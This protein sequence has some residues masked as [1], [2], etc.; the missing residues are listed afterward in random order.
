MAVVVDATGTADSTATNGTSFNYTGITVG[1]GSNRA[2]IF[3]LVTSNA[4]GNFATGATATWDSGGTNQAMTV[5]KSQQAT[6]DNNLG[7]VWIFGLRNPVAGNKTLAVAWTNA[8][9][10][11]ACAI[12]FT[13]VDQTSDAIAFP[14]SNSATATS[15]GLSLAITSAA[16]NI[17]ITG[18]TAGTIS[19]PNQT[20]I[21]LD[22]VA[23][24]DGGGQ[25]AAGAASVT[26]TWTNGATQWAMA[27]CDV[28][29]SG[30]ADVLM[31]QIWL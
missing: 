30:S 9:G 15:G 22:T 13:G 16:G 31:A 19:A 7:V 17:P 6:G 21:F 20:Q 12:S 1:S 14:N 3:I 27:G 23:I 4:G 8:N 28:F 25:R 5:I 11:G 10:H 2:L 18:A 26:F 29:A 24:D